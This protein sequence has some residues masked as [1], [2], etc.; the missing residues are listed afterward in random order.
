MSSKNLV[1][2]PYFGGKSTHLNR[3]L[4]LIDNTPHSSYFEAFC[5]SA[6]VAL[7]K[8]PCRLET[9]NDMDKHIWNFITVLR[10]KREDLISAL[11]LTPWSRH[12]HKISRGDIEKLPDVEWA[13]LFYVRIRQSYASTPRTEGAGWKFSVNGASTDSPVPPLTHKR[14]L[15]MLYDVADRL[16][17][18]QVE[19]GNAFRLLPIYDTPTTLHFVDP[20]YIKETR[21]RSTDKYN[22]ELT[23]DQHEELAGILSTLTGKVILCGYDNEIYSEILGDWNKITL[24]ARSLPAARNKDKKKSECIW[25]NYEPDALYMS[26]G[27]SKQ[28]SFEE[29]LFA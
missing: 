12:E 16:L 4:P 9:I 13:R 24:D 15:E 28:E 18:M 3:I 11:M 27:P 22:H 5:G 23:T 25:L 14:A 2:F 17:Q 20:P 19:N 6:A 29:L 8:K 7:N 26:H 1:M 10:T 21:G